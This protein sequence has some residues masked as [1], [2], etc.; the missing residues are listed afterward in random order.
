MK[1]SRQPALF[2]NARIAERT[3]HGV[4]P[5]DP[6]VGERV[7]HARCNLAQN[8]VDNLGHGVRDMLANRKC[9]GCK[10]LLVMQRRMRLYMRFRLERLA[11]AM[12]FASR[13]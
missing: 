1:R 7:R 13:Q 4:S 6:F 5:L 2:D 9:D 12:R 11:T 3:L 10:V 8:D